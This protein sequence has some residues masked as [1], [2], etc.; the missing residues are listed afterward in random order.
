[1]EYCAIILTPCTLQLAI[2]EN[3]PSPSLYNLMW[4]KADEALWTV[5][6]QLKMGRSGNISFHP[7]VDSLFVDEL[8]MLAC[9]IITAGS[10]LKLTAAGAP[11]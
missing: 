11:E 6:N 4:G 7:N 8:I 1:M 2:L 10:K 5:W 3:F 9:Y